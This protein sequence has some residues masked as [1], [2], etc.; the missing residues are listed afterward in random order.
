MYL[1]MHSKVL[2]L[3]IAEQLEL[4]YFYHLFFTVV[5]FN[6]CVFSLALSSLTRHSHHVFSVLKFLLSP[7][8]DSWQLKFESLIIL[9]VGFRNFFCCL[10]WAVDLGV[11]SV[12][13]TSTVNCPSQETEETSIPTRLVENV[14]LR[15]KGLQERN[16]Q[17]LHGT[18]VET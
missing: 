9:I 14:V 7:G 2:N 16:T 6:S 8:L 5:P 11:Q 15:T 12:I 10:A 4:I 1:F 18:T 17:L 13:E 3:T